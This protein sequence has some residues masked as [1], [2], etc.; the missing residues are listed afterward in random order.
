MS[1]IHGLFFP[2]DQLRELPDAIP[3]RDEII[4][5]PDAIPL[6]V[7]KYPVGKRLKVDITAY[8]P[9]EIT[10]SPEGATL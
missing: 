6:S 5:H 7:L 10:L 3:C 1:S 2:K 8:S 9:P 4:P